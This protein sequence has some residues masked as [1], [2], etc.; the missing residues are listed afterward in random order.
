MKSHLILIALCVSL[1]AFGQPNA[2]SAQVYFNKALTEKTAK[3]FLV[4]AQYFDKAIKF[5][6]DFTQAYIGLGQVN[7]EMRRTDQARVSFLQANKLEP[8]NKD[9]IKELMQLYFSYR[10]FDKAIEF[11]NK[12]TACP[13]A[14]RVVGMSY[15]QQ[16][17]YPA[18]VKA[19]TAALAQDNRDAEATYTLARTYLDMEEYDKAVPWYIKATTLDET[20]SSWMY[21]LGLLYFNNN[22][23]GDAAAAFRKAADHGYAQTSDFNENL[24]YAALNSGDYKSGEELL[25]AVYKKKPGKLDILRDMSEI[26]YEKHLYDKSLEYCQKLMELNNQDS[27]ALYQAGLCFQKKGA[28]EKGQ[29][30]CD[31]AINMDPSLA[32]LRKKQEMP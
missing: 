31:K 9:V 17:D 20:K 14:L 23:Y 1:T 8:S 5:K 30:M 19:L 10:E 25:L 2:D 6:P 3:R 16:E 28:K 15:Y 4:A 18:A 22:H 12:C 32:S 27:K 11:A 7:L 29:Q 21:E 26:F 24:G 13:G